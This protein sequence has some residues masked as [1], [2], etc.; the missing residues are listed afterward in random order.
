MSGCPFA[1]SRRALLAG[2]AALATVARTAHAAA[3]QAA[4]DVEPFYGPHQS[5]ILTPQQRHSYFAAFDLSTTKRQDVI[6]LLRRWTDAAARMTQ[7]LPLEADAGDAAGLSPSRLTVT[8]GF[9]PSLFTKDGADR[10]NLA[11]LRP[12]ALVDMPKFPGDQLVAEKS[13][14]DLS[15]QVCAN[16]PQVA[17]HA[18]RELAGLAYET[19]TTRWLQSGFTPGTAPGETPRNLMGF[20]D[21]SNNPDPNDPKAMNEVVWSGDD[22]PAWMRG[23]SYV[24]VRRSR[25]AL[26][27]WDRTNVSFQEQTIGRQKASGAPLGAKAEH[28][29]ANYDAEDVDGNQVIPENSHVRL[30]SAE[31]NDGARIYRR[32]YSFNDGVAFTAERWPPWRQEMELDAGL[33]FICY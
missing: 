33:L 8:F 6:D 17:F 13:D 11:K 28:D 24:V 9:G 7:G 4:T 14:G 23:G 20:K 15:I 19:A 29:P 3:S 25:I 10:Y 27:H 18:I 5:G 21:G 22:G 30:A 32:A 12:P 16:D 2:S 31:A 1:L 26:E